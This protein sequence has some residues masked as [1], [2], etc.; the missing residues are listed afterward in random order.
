M[1]SFALAFACQN[2]EEDVAHE[3]PVFRNCWRN[4]PGQSTFCNWTLIKTKIASPGLSPAWR[5][6]MMFVLRT[7]KSASIE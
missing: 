3:A 7:W 6:S 1:R 2:H 4:Y 5:L